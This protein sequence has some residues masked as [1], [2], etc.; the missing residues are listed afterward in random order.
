MIN[1]PLTCITNGAKYAWLMR[2]QELLRREHNIMGGWFRE[3]ITLTKYQKLR[4]AVQIAFPYATGKLSSED[5]KRYQ[6]TRFEKKLDMLMV[7]V[8]AKR[9][10]CF[11]S[12][13]HSPNLDDD[14]TADT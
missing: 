2:A 9:K 1:Y 14:I 5:W 7:E 11:E 6:E 13:T 10:L 4:A 12:T 3:G 8:G